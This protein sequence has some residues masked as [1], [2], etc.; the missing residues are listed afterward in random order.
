M[1][2][3]ARR[4]LGLGVV[5]APL[6]RPTC[7]QALRL[8]ALGN[9]LAGNAA[10]SIPAWSG[11]LPP[12]APG[13]GF[14]PFAADPV[15]ATLGPAEAED[16]RLPAGLAALL[17]TRPG[18]R[19]RLHPTRRT[20]AVPDFVLNASAANLGRARL[21][22]VGTGVR[23]AATGIPFPRP[24]NGLQAIWNHMLR[25]RFA[26]LRRRVA[27]ANPL[28]SGDYTLGR[29]LDRT[30]YPYN[31]P[32]SDPNDP[33][34][35]SQLL[36][37]VVQAPASLARL[38]LLSRQPL[39]YARE[40]T[41]YWFYSPQERRVT[42]SADTVFDVPNGVADGLRTVDQADVFSG[43]PERY[44]WTLL[45]KREAIL[46]YNAY[47]LYDPARR[48]A[49]LLRPGGLNPRFTR[50]ELHRAFVVEARLKP[51]MAHRYAR[52][53]LYLDED[54]WQA[55]LAEHYDAA[56]RLV[57]VTEAHPIQYRDPPS[58]YASIDLV[59]DLP[60]GRYAVFGLPNEEP[61]IEARAGLSAPLTPA[62]FT[63]DA[64]RAQVE[65]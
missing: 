45:G 57:R 52:R 14:D 25:W 15:L 54:S 32:D 20:G 38:A 65:R 11:G 7:A 29:W 59:H 43:S 16:P 58:L 44:D 5:A 27:T 10:G 47:A 51:G 50:Y 24:E 34:R 60:S 1:P 39:D 21:T 9:D 62:D 36:I 48:Y 30:I 55:L 8:G 40:G 12:T 31:A 42:Y 26:A 2:P 46:P 56:G 37:Y 22:E 64:F 18:F 33:G 23:G 6:A 49:E 28:A 61:P 19:V 35:A 3:L 17:R 41:G 4:A 13:G 63:P 53:V